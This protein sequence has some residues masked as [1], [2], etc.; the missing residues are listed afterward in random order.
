MRRAESGSNGKAAKAVKRTQVVEILDSSDEEAAAE[1]KTPKARRK[2]PLF[3]D[4][5]D[6]DDDAA[7]YK[8]PATATSDVEPD[9][10]RKPVVKADGKG[11]KFLADD[12]KSSTKI[13][14]LVKVRW[15][16]SGETDPAEPT[17]DPRAGRECLHRRLQQVRMRTVAELTLQ[18]HRLPRPDPARPGPRGIRVLPAR[19]HALAE[20]ARERP[21]ALQ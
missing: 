5:S 17:Q 8:P 19:R 13:D 4:E 6:D 20:A 1:V 16:P 11:K 2:K 10:E 18:L 14:A 7:A 3:A 12:V 15:R 9:E 21:P